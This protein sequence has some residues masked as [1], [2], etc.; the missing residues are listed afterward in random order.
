MRSSTFVSIRTR[1]KAF[2]RIKMQPVVHEL[3]EK[4]LL[5]ESRGAQVVELEDYGMPA[6]YYFEI[7]RLLSLCH[8]GYGGR[9]LPQGNVRFL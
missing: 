2:I 5:V 8:A 3:K 9:D 7:G 4:G 6:L 1:E